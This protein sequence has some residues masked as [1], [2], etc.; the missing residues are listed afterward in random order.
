V[1]KGLLIMRRRSLDVIRRA[2]FS[3]SQADPGSAEW[4][5]LHP[6][7]AACRGGCD[8]FK[9]SDGRSSTAQYP[10]LTK[11]FAGFDVNA[12]QAIADRTLDRNRQGAN[13]TLD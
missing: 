13:I 3:V 12:F 8:A 6:L 2:S 7:P 10:T 5:G 4:V 1:S 11:D 9:F